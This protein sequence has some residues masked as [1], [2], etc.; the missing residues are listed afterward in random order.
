[1]N[2]NTKIYSV[3]ILSL[4]LLSVY[5]VG[6]AADSLGEI[7][8]KITDNKYLQFLTV[9]LA[10]EI[11]G[12]DPG[13]VKP[14]V[15]F[16]IKIIYGF[17]IF[18]VLFLASKQ[19]PHLKEHYR[20]QMAVTLIIS[21]IATLSTPKALLVNLF[22]IYGGVF[23]FAFLLLPLVGL[24]IL[25]FLAEGKDRIHHAARALIT[26]PLIWIWGRVDPVWE[27]YK[28]PAAFLPDLAWFIMG[29]YLAWQIIGIIIG[30][31]HKGKLE[32]LGSVAGAGIGQKL[33]SKWAGKGEEDEK[34]V[35]LELGVARTFLL[36]AITAGE[37]IVDEGFARKTPAAVNNVKADLTKM[38]SAVKK[39]RE[40]LIAAQENAVGS[41]RTNLR[42]WSNYTMRIMTNLDE[43]FGRTPLPTDANWDDKVRF[44]KEK[45]SEEIG[46][47]GAVVEF[48][49]ELRQSGSITEPPAAGGGGST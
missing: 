27:T 5:A 45:V 33:K 17:L 31:E 35:K 18:I 32:G 25:L 26:I 10:E 1:M 34:E 42:R 47:C 22:K 3:L 49:D 23:L 37:K 9:D 40:E 36:N 7:Y 12:K 44:V 4:L 16:F 6:V 24:Y 28:L 38:R 29:A 21:L 30:S 13:S 48:I 15:I 14:E 11:V 19:I 39:A 41:N 20:I 46:Q 8:E 43:A 2:K